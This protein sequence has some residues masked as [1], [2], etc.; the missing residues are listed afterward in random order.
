MLDLGSS[1]LSRAGSNPVSCITKILEDR[2]MNKAL[3]VLYE[4]YQAQKKQVE[5]AQRELSEIAD[6]LSEER[7]KENR[8]LNNV[9]EDRLEEVIG[10]IHKNNLGVVEVLGAEGDP[11]DL[12][13]GI[14]NNFYKTAIRIKDGEIVQDT[15]RYNNDG[16]GA[17]LYEVVDKL[18]DNDLR[19]FCGSHRNQ[20]NKDGYKKKYWEA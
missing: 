6:A 7:C 20:Y 14:C 1:E 10:I 16:G 13:I 3:E 9:I 8:F 2:L 4:Q 12:I 17:K 15:S 5:K 18:I 19:F 11:R